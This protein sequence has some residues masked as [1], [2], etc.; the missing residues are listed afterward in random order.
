[1]SRRKLWSCNKDLNPPRV[2]FQPFARKTDPRKE[3]WKEKL[4]TFGR[5]RQ[6][7]ETRHPEMRCSEWTE[8][9]GLIE[10][11]GFFLRSEIAHLLR[12]HSQ[13]HKVL[14]KL[15][16]KGRDASR[17]DSYSV[18]FINL[19]THL[20]FTAT[21]KWLSLSPF[22]RQGNRGSGWWNA[23]P[24]S[25]LVRDGAAIPL[26]TWGFQSLAGTH[27]HRVVCSPS[28][29]TSLFSPVSLLV[30]LPAPCNWGRGGPLLPRSI[31]DNP[32]C[33]A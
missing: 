33:L 19:L 23:L 11:G 27:L 15:L 28:L 21:V 8:P 26:R 32:L 2:I 18:L 31:F 24:R 7:D 6:G 9:T 13:H 1:M 16:G 20:T 5:Q 12:H 22:H 17:D 25:H 4:R 3:V 29:Q 30:S 14:P 10:E